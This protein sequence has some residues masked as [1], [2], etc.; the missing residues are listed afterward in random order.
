MF[1]LFPELV[2][3]EVE[4][5]SA[6]HVSALWRKYGRTPDELVDGLEDPQCSKNKVSRKSAG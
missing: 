6:S 2:P 3:D 1:K 4:S 5:V